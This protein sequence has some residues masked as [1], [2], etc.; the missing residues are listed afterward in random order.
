MGFDVCTESI[1]PENMTGVICNRWQYFLR[2]TTERTHW[3]FICAEFRCANGYKWQLSYSQGIFRS[4]VRFVS[5]FTSIFSIFVCRTPQQC[6]LFHV[7]VEYELLFIFKADEWWWSII[8]GLHETRANVFICAY[9][10]PFLVFVF[11]LLCRKLYIWY[12]KR[13]NGY[14]NFSVNP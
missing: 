8:L 4:L 9:F 5:C 2:S 10:F 3:I 1:Y 13:Y 7:E 6:Q 12:I 11:L 14:Q